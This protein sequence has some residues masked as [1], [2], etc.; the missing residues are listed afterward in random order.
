MELGSPEFRGV[1]AAL[2]KRKIGFSGNICCKNKNLALREGLSF[3]VLT[4]I[5]HTVSA[6]TLISLTSKPTVELYRCD[7]FS[8]ISVLSVRDSNSVN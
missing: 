2:S 3:Y 5:F 1:H 6:L 4:F 8:T 7:I